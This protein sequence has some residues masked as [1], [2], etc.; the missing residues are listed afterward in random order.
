MHHIFSL[1]PY[2][3]FNILQPIAESHVEDYRIRQICYDTLLSWKPNVTFIQRM[4]LHSNT[5][6]SV[7]IQSFIYWVIDSMSRIDDPSYREL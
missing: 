7:Q 4:A 5:E 2:Q 6:P 1:I 3:I